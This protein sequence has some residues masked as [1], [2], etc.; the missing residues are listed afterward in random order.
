MQYSRITALALLF[1]YRHDVDVN[2]IS[3]FNGASLIEKEDVSSFLMPEL[4]DMRYSEH[5]N[6]TAAEKVASEIVVKDKSDYDPLANCSVT[7]QVRIIQKSPQ[8]ILQSV[9]ASGNDKTVGGDEF[10]V[11][12]RDNKR[13]QN[14]NPT[15][16]ALIKDLANGSYVLDFVATPMDPV[17]LNLTSVGKLTIH[18]EYT[19]TIG[20]AHQPTKANWK[21]GGA[22]LIH[23][24][25]SN[26]TQPP[27]RAFQFPPSDIDLSPFDLVVSFGDSMMQTFVR[28][29][30]GPTRYFREKTGYHGNPKMELN[31]KTLVFMLKK[32]ERWHGVQHLRN[33]AR[34][35]ALLLGSSAWEITAWDI[36]EPHPNA[37]RK[38]QDFSDHLDACR[39]FVL[40]V[41][42]LYPNVT[43][44]WKAP[45]A[46][47]R[48][49][50]ADSAPISHSST[51]LA[52]PCV[53]CSTH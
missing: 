53:P 3:S 35:V 19:C 4:S 7:S 9:H 30:K 47:V 34:D 50:M 28:E 13:P 42:A 29:L 1:V 10:Y 20:R 49:S 21:F 40:Q 6:M 51:F 15:A 38:R 45:A 43:V 14:G 26:I 24:S 8:W 2:S 11:T 27:I 5:D 46:M 17:P 23:H 12:Y 37:N 16:V 36:T 48:T 41:Q 22:T 25:K 39:R 18:F 33:S 52:V 32:M 44:M 31:S